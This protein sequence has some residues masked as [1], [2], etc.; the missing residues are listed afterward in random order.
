M[1]CGKKWFLMDFVQEQ[2]IAEAFPEKEAYFAYKSAAKAGRGKRIGKSVRLPRQS[3]RSWEECS[4]IYR[5]SW[6]L[7]ETMKDM[8]MK[9]GRCI[10]ITEFP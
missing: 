2:Y 9:S 6:N 5:K 1:E 3:F 4:G 8:P 7:E 10:P